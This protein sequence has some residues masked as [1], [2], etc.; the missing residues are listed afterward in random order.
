MVFNSIEYAIFLTGIFIIYWSIANTNLKFQNCFL[1]ITNYFFYGWWDWR[2][3]ILLLFI[4]GTNYLVGI[5]FS[6]SDNAKMRKMLLLIALL[7]CFSCLFLFKYY[8]FF[9]NSIAY[10]INMIGAHVMPIHFSVILPIGISF[11]I[12]QSVS[13][14]IDVYYHK[15]EPEKDAIAFLA[16]SS[17]FPLLLSGPIERGTTLL[18]QFLVKR[19]FIYTA[20]VD[21]MRQ[22]LWGLF[23]KIVIADNCNIY[24]NKVFSDSMNYTGSSLLLGALLF[25]IQIYADFSGYSDIAIGSARLLGFNVIRNFRLP[26]FSPNIIEFWKRWHISLTSWFRDYLY[27]TLGGNRRSRAI[28]IRNIFIVF[29]LSGL[30]HGANWT[31]IAW[32]LLHACCYIFYMICIH[33]KFDSSTI[34]HSRRWMIC[35]EIISMAA[36]FSFVT[37]AW[38]F[39]KAASIEHALLFLKGIFSRTIFSLPQDMPITTLL[40]V[41]IFFII[42]WVQRDK[43]EIFHIDDV[44]QSRFMRWAVYI[45]L[46]GIIFYCGV[47]Q[48]YSFIYFQF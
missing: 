45:A 10:S 13:Y 41:L 37:V 32:G 15:I 16:F 25:S 42:E 22:I 7:G 33:E 44:I 23:K 20:A 35:K 29:L 27:I 3:L 17:F 34:L 26:Y 9:S 46:L 28:W 14:S 1:L 11:Y 39:F 4:S 5:G 31:F 8:N 30:W 21:G 12:F 19:R 48:N 36:N 2:F 38:I 40:L 6:K 18:P 24:V 43:M 47:F